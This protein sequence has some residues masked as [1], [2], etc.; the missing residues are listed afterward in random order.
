M[1]RSARK[2]IECNG[3]WAFIYV[4]L[5]AKRERRPHGKTYHHIKVSGPYNGYFSEALAD[6]N[7]NLEDH[8][9]KQEQL[10]YD[11]ASDPKRKSAEEKLL[12]NLGFELEKERI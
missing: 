9:V 3:Q 11:W 5:N 4:N 2:K 7:G 12:E 8:V 1:E 6:A 10:F